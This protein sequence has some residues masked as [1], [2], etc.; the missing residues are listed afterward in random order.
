MHPL[1]KLKRKETKKYTH[2]ERLKKRKREAKSKFKPLRTKLLF[3]AKFDKVDKSG[4]FDVA[5][6][7]VS[8]LEKE[9]YYF[10]SIERRALTDHHLE[11]P[12]LTCATNVALLKSWN[13]NKSHTIKFIKL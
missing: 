7:Y 4:L 13:G 2:E 3:F 11:I 9:K 6:K 1:S 5:E 12:N 8:Y 10:A